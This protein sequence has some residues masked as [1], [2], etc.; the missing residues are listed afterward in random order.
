MPR[1]SYTNH[2][3]LISSHFL[4]MPCYITY[5]CLPKKLS[6]HSKSLNFLEALYTK[7]NF[8]SKNPTFVVHLRY[9]AHPPFF[10]TS[11]SLVVSR[12]YVPGRLYKERCRRRVEHLVQ[13]C[14]ISFSQVQRS[15]LSVSSFFLETLRKVTTMFHPI[16]FHIMV[17]RVSSYEDII[18]FDKNLFNENIKKVVKHLF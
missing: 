18:S 10:I 3:F 13:C 2:D 17:P 4:L 6:N 16:I 9:C 12:F 15:W 11:N 14:F 8:K 7:V 5:T 1:N